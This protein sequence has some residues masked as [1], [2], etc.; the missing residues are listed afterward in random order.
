MEKPN[1]IVEV[2]SL[3]TLLD[4]NQTL[5]L[6]DVRQP[7]ENAESRIPGSTLIPLGELNQRASEVDQDVPTI[8]YCAS[9]IRS[10]DA[11]MALKQLGFKQV[12][13]LEGGIHAWCDAGYQVDV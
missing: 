11:L 12:Q 13:H 3:K 4:S 10:L 8:V 2:D 7:E 5:Q 1:W 9:G 6:I